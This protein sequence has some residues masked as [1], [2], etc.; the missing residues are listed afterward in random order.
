MEAEF[1]YPLSVFII[2]AVWRNEIAIYLENTLSLP[3]KCPF[4]FS[5]FLGEAAAASR[6]GDKESGSDICTPREVGK[7]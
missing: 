6:A 1:C 7:R 2:V 3:L 4:S 5:G